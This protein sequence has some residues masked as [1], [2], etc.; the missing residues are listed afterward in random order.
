MGN[1][2]DE[3]GTGIQ[4]EAGLTKGGRSD[5]GERER[6]KGNQGKRKRNERDEKGI[7]ADGN[8]TRVPKGGQE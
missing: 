7:K 8:G 2:S 6:R 1:E 5:D 4:W 3:K